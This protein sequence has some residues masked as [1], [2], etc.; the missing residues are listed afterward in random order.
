[1]RGAPVSAL[2]VGPGFHVSSNKRI[3]VI[4][5]RDLRFQYED[6]TVALAGVDFQLHSG[7]TVAL[8]GANGSGK[9]TFVLHL[10]GLLEGGGS[11]EVCGMPVNKE[12]LQRVRQKIGVVFQDPDDQLFMP[13]VLEDVA[14]GALNIGLPPDR[15]SERA[16]TALRQVGMIESHDKAPCHL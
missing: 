12:T 9:T 3:P 6:G 1:R 4:S 2:V 15:A 14:F 7:E 13:S 11:I 8:F 10:N 5:V 16:R